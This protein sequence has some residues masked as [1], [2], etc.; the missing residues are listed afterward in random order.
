MTRPGNFNI[1][2][3]SIV[4][5]TS[6]LDMTWEWLITVDAPTVPNE[7]SRVPA[8]V[9]VGAL[10]TN[11]Q[12]IKGNMQ[13]S[14]CKQHV[15]GDW[16]KMLDDDN[17]MHE[18]YF[19]VILPIMKSRPDCAIVVN[20]INH[21]GQLRLV[22]TPENMRVGGVDHDQ[23]IFPTYMLDGWVWSPGDYCQ[24]GV[25]FHTRYWKYP[26]KFVFVRENLSWYNKLRPDWPKE[27]IR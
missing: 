9:W 6:G 21:D 16:I 13:R 5:A 1:I 18:R 15:T 17:M 26:D 27:H 20:Q 22:A 7:L 10:P 14:N 2:H 25:L 4:T 11:G 3:Q 8:N 24:D 23:G 19:R 12:G